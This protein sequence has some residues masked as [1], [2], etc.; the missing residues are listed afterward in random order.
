[1]KMATDMNSR[2]LALETDNQELRARL[3][4]L[5]A[6]QPPAKKS[7]AP[8]REDEGARVSV[9]LPMAN[10]KHLP[11]EDEARALLK[12]VTARYPKLKFRTADDELE[13]FRA[14][15]AFV[16]SRTKVASPIKKFAASWWIDT[17]QQWCRTAGVQGAVRSLA[18]PIIASADI[19]F[20]LD[21]FSTFWLDPHGVVGRAVD[22]QAWRKILNG[23]GDLVAPTKL[24]VFVDQSIGLQRVHAAW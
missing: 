19:P 6:A 14:G 5:E 17:A 1:M 9:F 7:I 3:V 15:F 21:D 13:S 20:T 16:C 24:D 12:I 18:A 10:P 4:A 11:T 8:H 22:A 23:S 2:L